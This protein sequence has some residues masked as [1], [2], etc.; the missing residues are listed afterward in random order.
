MSW[1]NEACLKHPSDLPLTDSLTKSTFN[2][3]NRTIGTCVKID[4]KRELGSSQTTNHNKQTK[5]SKD[6]IMLSTNRSL[7]RRLI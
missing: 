2:E 5:V 1:R 4:S 3:Q 7:I 6:I